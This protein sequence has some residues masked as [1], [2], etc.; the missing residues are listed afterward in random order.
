MVTKFVCMTYIYASAMP[1]LWG[2]LF[3][4]C[5]FSRYLDTRNLLRVLQPPPQSGVAQVRSYEQ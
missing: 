5:A 4:V 1:L 3:L 2:I